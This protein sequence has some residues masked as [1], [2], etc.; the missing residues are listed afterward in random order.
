MGRIHNGAGGSALGQSLPKMISMKKKW[1]RSHVVENIIRERYSL[2]CTIDE[3]GSTARVTVY[4]LDRIPGSSSKRFL[5][6]F[7]EAVC[8]IGSY[9][10]IKITVSELSRPMR[11]KHPKERGIGI[12][13]SKSDD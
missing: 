11:A 5:E 7:S 9:R 8:A 12:Y 4:D 10:A 13:S 3:N 2:D 6:E 1:K